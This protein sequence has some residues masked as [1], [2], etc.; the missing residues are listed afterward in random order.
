MN[1]VMNEYILL[2]SVQHVKAST[3]RQQVGSEPVATYLKQ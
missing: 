3:Y 1:S 2:Y